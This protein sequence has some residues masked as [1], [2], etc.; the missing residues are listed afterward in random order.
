MSG[1]KVDRIV[2]SVYVLSAVSSMIAGLVVTRHS[3]VCGT[4]EWGIDYRLTS[5]AAVV[6]GGTAF[7]GRKRRVPWHLRRCVIDNCA[8]QSTYDTPGG[9][10]L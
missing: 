1:V 2:I 8:K 7:A 6:M 4:L 5:M 10:N 3:G 9:V